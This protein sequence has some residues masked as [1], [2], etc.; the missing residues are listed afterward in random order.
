[1]ED[2]NHLCLIIIT[3]CFYLFSTDVYWHRLISN[4]MWRFLYHVKY[5][6]TFLFSFFFSNLQHILSEIIKIFNTWRHQVGQLHA[7]HVEGNKLL[8]NVQPARQEKKIALMFS[9]QWIIFD[10]N[11]K[12]KIQFSLLDDPASSL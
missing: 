9:L 1:M 8:I 7:Q 3:L 12:D 10:R 11:T 6:Y 5:F 4:R 2:T